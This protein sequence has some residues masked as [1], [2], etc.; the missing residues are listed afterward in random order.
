MKESFHYVF[1]KYY[2]RDSKISEQMFST[3]PEEMPLFPQPLAIK[4]ADRPSERAIQRP[5]KTG[6]LY[7]EPISS[8]NNSTIAFAQALSKLQRFL[9]FHLQ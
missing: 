2:F 9:C 8:N 6:Y 7:N 3:E 5:K 4:E 1:E